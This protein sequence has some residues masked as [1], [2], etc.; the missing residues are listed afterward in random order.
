M[1]CSLLLLLIV[2]PFR[3]IISLRYGIKHFN[4]VLCRRLSGSTFS[5]CN[6]PLNLRHNY[7]LEVF[8]DC[9]E[10]RLQ[11]PCVCAGNNFLL[12]LKTLSELMHPYN[13][14]LL[15]KRILKMLCICK[16]A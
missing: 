2:C 5:K 10:A 11:S 1:D 16:V 12:L 3:F 15:L 4:I 6:D 8:A 7:S 14:F 9:F 13:P